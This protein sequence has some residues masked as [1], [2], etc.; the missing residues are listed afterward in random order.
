MFPTDDIA[1]AYNLIKDLQPTP[2][3]HHYDF[4]ILLAISFIKSYE[5]VFPD[6]R[7]SRGIQLDQ[8]PSANTEFTYDFNRLLVVSFIKSY[9]LVFRDRRHSGGIQP[10]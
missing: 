8:G 2:S 3:L 10:D 4:N 6:R 7:H 5:F 1:E 9:E